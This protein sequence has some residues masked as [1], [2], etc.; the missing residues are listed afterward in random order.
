MNENVAA[1]QLCAVYLRRILHECHVTSEGQ[2]FYSRTDQHTSLIANVGERQ[3]DNCLGCVEG[4][5]HLYSLWLQD[6]E[7][8]T[9]NSLEVKRT[10]KMAYLPV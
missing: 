2:L 5:A 9:V 1:P 4:F 8:A 10:Y 7:S 3:L 6:L